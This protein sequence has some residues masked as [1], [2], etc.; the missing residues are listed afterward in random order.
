MGHQ[1]WGLGTA[2]R[3]VPQVSMLPCPMVLSPALVVSLCQG[4]SDA[5]CSRK[6]HVESPGDPGVLGSCHSP[7]GH[8]RTAL[9]SCMAF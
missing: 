7:R 8:W 6:G 2:V 4:T 5:C 9:G 3:F 1:A